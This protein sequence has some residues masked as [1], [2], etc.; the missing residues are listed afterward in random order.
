MSR[1][2]S[3]ICQQI[4]HSRSK[5]NAAWSEE[6]FKKGPDEEDYAPRYLKNK[7]EDY[8]CPGDGRE[9]SLARVD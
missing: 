9:S 8:F 6:G 3:E 5:A 4:F 2:G 1:F 7:K